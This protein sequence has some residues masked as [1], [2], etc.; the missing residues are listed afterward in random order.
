MRKTTFWLFILAPVF[1]FAQV[2]T[3][4]T[5]NLSA[6]VKAKLDLDNDTSTATLT[7]SGPND[8]WFAL[9]FGSFTNGMANG[10]DLV[11][12]NNV[13]LVDSKQTGQ[14][15]TPSNDGTNNWTVVSNTNNSPAAGQRTIVATRAFSTGDAND[16]TFTFSAANIDMAWARSSSASYNLS[17]HGNSNRG[18]ALNQNFTTLG[19]EDLSL[20][21]SV[22]YPNPSQSWFAVKTKTALERINVYSQ[23]G[24]FVKTVEVKALEAT[25]VRV[26]GLSSG[27][28]LLELVNASENAWKK[29]IVE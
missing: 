6:N 23:T 5:L 2:K 13:T 7:L 9:A 22:V 10:T 19:V 12:W 4:G 11:Y 14:G 24:A 1:A 21:S 18:E 20:A 26:D 8:R 17:N 29:L 3:T 15:N 16:F 25:E 27:I 28:Y